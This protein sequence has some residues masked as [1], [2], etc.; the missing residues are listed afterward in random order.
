VLFAYAFGEY[1]SLL[2]STPRFNGSGEFIGTLT[3]TDWVQVTE[4]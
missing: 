4:K 1:V 2:C 3:C